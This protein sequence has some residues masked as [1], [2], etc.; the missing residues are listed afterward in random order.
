MGSGRPTFEQMNLA[1]F[2]GEDPGGVLWQ[3]RLEFWYAVNRKRGTLPP[4]YR[5]ASLL[6]LYDDCLASVRYF[7]HPL[8]ARQHSVS[9]SETRLDA[10]RV[11]HEWRTPLGSL[12]EV[13]HYDEWDLSAYHDEYKVK[14]ADDLR[15]L[16]Y[17]VEDQEWWWDQGEY[18]ADLARI[19]RRGAAQFYFRR[20]PLQGLFIEHMGFERTI[21]ALHDHP[22]QV[23]HYLE[24]AA[25][26]DDAAYDA[27]TR[28][29]VPIVNFGENIDA[30]MDPPAIWNGRLMPY[31]RRRTEQLHAAGK[32]VHIH[33]D[34]AM[35]PL[36]PYMRACPWD[37]IEAATPVPQGDVTLEEIK[38]ALGPLVLLDGIPAVYFLP[39]FPE[40]TLYECVEQVV[41]LFHPRLVLGI[42][43]EIPPDG[44]IR[45]VKRVGEMVR[46]MG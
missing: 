8:K 27:I 12:S 41:K 45:R 20:S 21:Y 15:I 24:V 3:P 30:H 4:G 14:T 19:D 37:G 10:K 16:E 44:D 25:R 22:Q 18:E 17:I 31:Y 38:Q 35:R 34:G 9:V 43:D 42:S 39:S 40:E 1:I 29:P 5:D 7:T 6:D 26:A 36:L 28:C 46:G 32:R 11:A 33:V 23:E 2:A 13:T